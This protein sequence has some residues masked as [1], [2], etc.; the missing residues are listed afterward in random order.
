MDNRGAIEVKKHFK[1]T[2]GTIRQTGAAKKWNCLFCKKTITG[3]A[4]KLKAHLLGVRGFNVAAC[5]EISEDTQSA[6]SLLEAE[7]SDKK[8][9]QPARSYAL[10][11]SNSSR[12]PGIADVFARLILMLW[13]FSWPSSSMS[14][15]SHSML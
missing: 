10:S 6:I 14:T 3:S 1:L 4:T 9:G 5:D 8:A 11:S 7:H 13:T 12:Q 15:G 2:G